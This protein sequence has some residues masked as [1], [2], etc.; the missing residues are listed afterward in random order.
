MTEGE[1]RKTVV[2]DA[3]PEV[4]FKALTDEKEL[5]RWM[6]QEARMDPRLGGE[7]EFKYHWA[8]KG[9]HSVATGKILELIPSKRLSYTYVLTRSGSGTSEAD[10]LFPDVTNSVVTW[11]LDA[12]P[13]GKTR[14]TVVHS[15][16]TKG[17]YERFDGSWGYWTGQ[18]ARHGKVMTGRSK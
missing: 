18:L 17:A 2:V 16:M 14:V 8:K 6:P 10:S 13:D 1:I 11:T 12:L 3:P 4:V 7:Y 5:V 9:L 15:G